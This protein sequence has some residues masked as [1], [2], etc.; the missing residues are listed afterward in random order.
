[1]VYAAIALAVLTG[2][3]SGAAII[4]WRWHTPRHAAS[5][6]A[7]AKT[8][9]SRANDEEIRRYRMAINAMTK[10]TDADRFDEAFTVARNW[11]SRAPQFVDSWVKL[12]GTFDLD[13]LPPVE[14]A[15]QHLVAL[16]DVAGLRRLRE[17][18]MARD[19]LKPW[20]NLLADE[21]VAANELGRIF[22]L[23][24]RNPGIAQDTAARRVGAGVRR[25]FKALHD[26]DVR[27][28]IRRERSGGGYELYLR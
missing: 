17:A 23:V 7:T 5:A 21:I 10:L 9:A 25:A 8:G 24:E 27:D 19:E 14:Y 18:M 11:C 28:L 20:Q 22:D 16:R 3:A 12:K 15:A 1:M 6:R 26:A 13:S 2:I 4:W